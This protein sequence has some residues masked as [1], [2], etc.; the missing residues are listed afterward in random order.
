LSD[1]RF[2]PAPILNVAIRSQNHSKL[3]LDEQARLAC[4][5]G[6]NAS[7]RQRRDACQTNME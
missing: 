2:R 1:S 5:D 4:C 6:L 3:I 7:A